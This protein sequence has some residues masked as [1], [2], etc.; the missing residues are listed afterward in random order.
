MANQT[1]PL[2]PLWQNHDARWKE[3]CGWDIPAYFTNPEEEYQKLITSAVLIDQSYRGKIMVTGNNR[4]TFLNHMLTNDITAIKQNNSC[5]ALLL[6][7]QGRCLADFRVFAFNDFLLLDT[8]PQLSEASIKLLDKFI[9]AEDVQLKNVTPNYIHLGIEGPFAHNVFLKLSK[10]PF[11]AISWMTQ[12]VSFSG[13]NAVALFMKPENAAKTVEELLQQGISLCGHAALERRR[14]E[15]KIPRFKKDFDEN[16]F[17]N[18]TGLEETAASETKGCYP[19]QEVVA[20]LK[21]YG[22]VKR[23]LWN[24]GNASDKQA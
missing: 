21:T 12:Y 8:E 5:R 1:L 11:E 9:I 16:W 4:I 17:L 13:E 19:G 22:G 6:S 24:R 14:T 15:N 3:D 2:A 18:E 10:Q 20:R 23:S 7:A